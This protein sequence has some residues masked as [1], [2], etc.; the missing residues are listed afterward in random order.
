MGRIV[1]PARYVT[2]SSPPREGQL[3][4]PTIQGQPGDVVALLVSL[5]DDFQPLAGKHG[6]LLLDTSVLLLFPSSWQH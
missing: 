5:V 2:I 3:G 4:A 1:P 6:V